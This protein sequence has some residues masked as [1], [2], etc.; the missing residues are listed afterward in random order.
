MKHFDAAFASAVNPAILGGVKSRILV[1]AVVALAW[2]RPLLAQGQRVSIDAALHTSDKP[3]IQAAGAATISAKPDQAVVEIGVVSQASNANAASTQN[4][5]Q[6]DT[7]L[8]ELNTLLGSSKKV[9]TT[10]YSVRPT[11]QYPKPGAAPT[12]SGYTVT[13]VVEVTLDDLT[14]VSKVIDTATQ[15]GANIVQKLQYRLKN[16]N[17]V[18]ARALREAAEQ[19][20]LSAEA[21]A[22]GV[23]L[24]LVRVLSVEEV[25][26]DEGFAMYKKAIP[27]PPPTGTVATPL[28]IGTIDVEVNVILRVEVAQ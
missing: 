17:G 6:T 12:I 4:A 21:M 13:N 3:Y 5:K 15:S 20:K 2:C 25:A 18:R 19:A 28:E 11:F 22:A 26:P 14:Q 16:P 10:S 27:P 23:G 1:L 9:R 24:K 8:G 7:V